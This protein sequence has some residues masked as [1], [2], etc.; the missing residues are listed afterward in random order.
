MH[1]RLGYRTASPFDI[2]RGLVVR[3]IRNHINI[4]VVFIL[5]DVLY[6]EVF[7]Q[8]TISLPVSSS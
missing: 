6:I 5:I 8:W 4:V 2:D 7:T 3:L 1:N